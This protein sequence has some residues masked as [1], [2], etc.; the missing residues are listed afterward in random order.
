MGGSR[1]K[2]AK[3]SG[4]SLGDLGVRTVRI[5]KDEERTKGISA[6][7]PFPLYRSSLRFLNTHFV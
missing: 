5:W 1:L 6:G 4:L 3:P 7:L 2:K